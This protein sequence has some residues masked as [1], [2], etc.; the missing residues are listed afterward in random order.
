MATKSLYVGNLPHGTTEDELRELFAQYG[1]VESV[2]V[3]EGKG[4]AF[5]D[6]SDEKA[7]DAVQ[8]LTGA[9]F[10][11]R[12]LRV[13]E[14][15]PRRERSDSDRGFRGGGGGGGGGGGFRREGRG[16]PRNRGPRW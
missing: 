13:D 16:G 9:D 15:R 6:I 2:R 3:I 8:A 10:K 5:V 1:P 4:F 12:A 11:G 14:A 7:G